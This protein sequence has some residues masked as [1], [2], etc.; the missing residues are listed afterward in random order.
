MP[1]LTNY[2]F[3]EKCR[4]GWVR[5]VRARGAAALR[6]EPDFGMAWDGSLRYL[7]ATAIA[8]TLEGRRSSIS[9]IRIGL[10]EIVVRRT[11]SGAEISVAGVMIHS[12][13]DV[14]LDR[15]QAAEL[16]KCLRPPPPPV[17]AW[18]A[19]ADNRRDRLMKGIF[20]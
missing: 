14:E 5:A 1:M 19:G 12:K 15:R 3:E 20:G 18:N 17:S 4:G 9:P 8:D 13:V 16:A 10:E 11:V 6:I 7:E 2:D